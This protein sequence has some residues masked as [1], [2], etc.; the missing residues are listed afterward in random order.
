MKRQSHLLSSA[1]MGL[2]FMLGL[3]STPALARGVPAQAGEAENPADT[4]CFQSFYGAITNVCSTTK[5]Y[6]VLLPVDTANYT[7]TAG[8]TVY[9]AG[10]SNTVGCALCGMDITTGWRWCT[11]LNYPSQ[12]GVDQTFNLSAYTSTGGVL[13]TCNMSPS[14]RLETIHWW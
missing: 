7:Y 8:V 9:A 10:P 5:Q 3:V 13:L 14:G 2:L 12:Y 4:N 1:L 11:S 6:T